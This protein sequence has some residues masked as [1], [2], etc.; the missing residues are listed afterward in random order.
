MSCTSDSEGALI[1]T[2]TL[3]LA[4]FPRAGA[5]TTSKSATPTIRAFPARTSRAW[6]AIATRRRTASV[7][8]A[9]IRRPT[10]GKCSHHRN[11]D[12]ARRMQPF[13]VPDLAPLNLAPRPPSLST[14]FRY[15]TLAIFSYRQLCETSGLGQLRDDPRWGQS[16]RH[17]APTRYRTTS[18]LYSA[19][20]CYRCTSIYAPARHAQPLCTPLPPHSP[21]PTSSSGRHCCRLWHYHCLPAHRRRAHVF[22]QINTMRAFLLVGSH[23]AQSC[24]PVYHHYSYS[25]WPSPYPNPCCSFIGQAPSISSAAHTALRP[26]EPSRPCRRMAL[27]RPALWPYRPWPARSPCR[28]QW[29]YRCPQAK[30]RGEPRREHADERLRAVV[31]IHDPLPT[32]SCS[33]YTML[34]RTALSPGLHPSGPHSLDPYLGNPVSSTSHMFRLEATI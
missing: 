22:A 26:R 9:M 29:P 31:R 10:T 28:R 4:R 8:T 11:S 32:T 1:L 30:S 16:R 19:A 2:L 34:A 12:L 25:P 13:H 5:T 20:P 18:R 15:P 7:S 14:L 23:A 24:R 3:T 6:T 21:S 27:P 17:G 33:A